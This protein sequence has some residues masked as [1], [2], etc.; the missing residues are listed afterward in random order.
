MDMFN[1]IVLISIS[2][3]LI[4]GALVMK[5]EN[6]RSSILFKVIPFFLGLGSLL[7]LNNL[8]NIVPYN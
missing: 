6:L 8:L 4:G 3:Y 1:I 5:T 7:V 2:V